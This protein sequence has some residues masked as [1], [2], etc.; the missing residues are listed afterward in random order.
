MNIFYSILLGIIQGLTE[1]LPISSSGHLV[2]FQKLLGIT[3]GQLTFNIFLHF[4]TLIPVLII[5]WD[6][7]RDIIL[8]KKSKKHLIWLILIGTIPT[9]MIGILFED[10]FKGLFSSVTNTGY[11]LLVTGTLLLIAEKLSNS[12]RNIDEFKT[13]NSVI[14]GIAQG[15]AIIPGISRSGSTIV[16][17]LLQDLNREEAARF[18]FLLSIPAIGGAGIL[19]LKDAI[20]IGL[21]GISWIAIITGTLAS[22]IAGYIAIKYLLHILKNGS[23]VVFSYY[24]WFLGLLTI[25]ITKLY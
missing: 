3:K 22:A 24:C 2:I 25:I 18:S 13:S 5:F 1:F 6:D 16:A 20:T 19:E 14:V 9:G 11:M 15:L 17:S 21:S 10:F 23:L 8:L 4:G 12:K 7:I